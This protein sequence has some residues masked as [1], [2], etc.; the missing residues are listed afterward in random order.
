[1][2]GSASASAQFS[3]RRLR[4]VA[5]RFP[6]GVKRSIIP[7]PAPNPW[8]QSVA[9]PFVGNWILGLPSAFNR[10]S[11]CIGA[12]TASGSGSRWPRSSSHPCS[13]YAGAKTRPSNSQVVDSHE[14][15]NR[16]RS[17]YPC[18]CRPASQMRTRTYP[19]CHAATGRRD[20]Q[21]TIIT[22]GENDRIFGFAS[23]EPRQ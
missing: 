4:W 13:C 20:R 18:S 17:F 14:L 19:T 23:P 2:P 22:K 9:K 11:C 10:V 5:E 15:A 1:M 16:R 7:A 12:F 8:S 3:L 21:V 6:P